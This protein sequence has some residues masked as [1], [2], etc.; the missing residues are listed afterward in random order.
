MRRARRQTIAFAAWLAIGAGTL[1]APAHAENA[2]ASIGTVK[3]VR[4]QAWI[5]I[6]ARTETAAPGARLYE[7]SALRTG[8]GESTIGIALKDNTLISLGPSSE[9]SL[10]EYRFAPAEG[11]LALVVGMTRGTMEFL[12]GMIARLRPDAVVVNT[13]TGTLGVRGTRFLVKLEE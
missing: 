8:P 11:A 6:G 4:G 9:I 5:V 12:T 2:A 13:P 7:G 10:D 1:A 3:S